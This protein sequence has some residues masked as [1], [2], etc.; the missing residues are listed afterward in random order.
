[1]I[2]RMTFHRLLW[3][4]SILLLLCTLALPARAVS[5]LRDADMEYALAQVADPILRAAG[6]SASGTKILV[7]DDASLNAFV[8][9]NDAI[10]I[11]S[12]LIARMDRAAMLQAVIAHE[13]AHIANGHITRRMTNLGAARN[14]A[15]LGTALALLAGAASGSGEAAAGIAIGAQSSAQRQFLAHTRAEESSADQSGLRYMRSAGV[16]VSGMLDVMQ[17]F[18]GQEA[19]SAGRQ[20]PYIRSHPLSR[21]RLRAIEAFAAASARAETGG[22]TAADYWFLRAKGKLT[23]FQRRGSWTL[24][25]L[26]D[27]GAQDIAYMRE[28]V[29]R[30]RNSETNRAV[31]SINKAIALRP[32]DPFY[33]DL[34]GQILME[35]RQFN[36]AVNAHAQAVRLRPRDGL[37]QAGYGRALLAT[38]NDRAALQA[39]ENARRVDF[40][41]GSMLRDLSVAYAR[42]GQRG[43]ASLVTAERY[44]LRGRLEDAGIHAK[45][46]TGLLA[47]GSGP[48]QRAQDVLLA[49][50]RAAKK[51][52]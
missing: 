38:G 23:A 13:A 12:G 18:R 6:L 27:S 37:L 17:I 39:L 43:M 30:H 5:L 51:R 49:S 36:A 44:A 26:G 3:Q 14:A 10:Y 47:T 7:V 22:A 46:A 25:R 24:R 9:G 20:D 41:D 52:R 28:A 19:L 2:L 40:R 16:P 4:S 32:Q 35:S 15:A 11:H 34:K 8:I 1:M 48:W 31:A 21:D 45:R 50:E 29:A 33:Y 42:N